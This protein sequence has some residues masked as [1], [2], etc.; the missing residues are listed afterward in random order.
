MPEFGADTG[1]ATVPVH[2]AKSHVPPQAA[3]TTLHSAPTAPPHPRPTPAKP[4]APP[5]VDTFAPAAHTSADMNDTRGVHSARTQMPSGEHPTVPIS[6]YDAPTVAQPSPGPVTPPKPRP[7]QTPAQPPSRLPTPAQQTPATGFDS[8]RPGDVNLTGQSIGGYVVRK[9]LGHGGMGAVCLAHQVSLDRDVALKILPG[10]MASNPDFLMRF[11]RE[12]LSAAQLSHHNIIQVYDIG[13]QEQ[14]HFISMEFVRGEDLGKIVRRDG[15]LQPDDAAGFILQ[16]ARGLKYAHDHG[17]IHRDIK[18]DNIMV[19]EQ[20]IVKIAD[21]GLAKIVNEVEHGAS[22]PPPVDESQRRSKEVIAQAKGELTIMDVAMGTPAYMAPEQGRDA[23]SVDHRADQYSLGCTFYYLLAG[24]APYQG[25]SAVEIISKHQIE[26][27]TPVQAHVKHVPEALSVII[28]KMLEKE[29]AN[30][31]PSMGEVI[32]DIE[33]Y[34]GLESEKGPYTPREEH[35][36]VLEQRQAEFYSVPMLAKRRTGLLAFFGVMALAFVACVFGNAYSWAGGILGL[37]V[38]APFAHF[39][40]NG[41]LTKD[42]LFRRV[43][44]VFFGMTF[45]GWLAAAGSTALVLLVLW[46]L[47]L[48]WSWLAFGALGVGFAVAYQFLV[49]KPLRAARKPA[50]EATQEMLKVLRLRG[51]SEEA[52]MDFVSRFSSTHWEEFFEELFGY[53]EM[54][55][56]RAKWAK[57]DKVKPRKKHATWRDPLHRWLEGI[58]DSRRKAKEKR[59]LAKAE[60]NRLKS[61]GIAEA[62]AEKMAGEMASA[63]MSEGLLQPTVQLGQVDTAAGYISTITKKRRHGVSPVARVYQLVR[64]L[65]GAAIVALYGVWVFKPGLLQALPVDL[66]PWMMKLAFRGEG[67][68]IL[69]L[70]AAVIVAGIMLFLTSATSRVF[71]TTLTFVGALLMVFFRYVVQFGGE[72]ELTPERVFLAGAIMVTVGFLI[73]VVFGGRR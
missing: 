25:K 3:S 28:Q 60:S 4:A 7:A 22:M 36:Q 27:L 49:S 34:L 12:A 56:A 32:K 58:E 35:L 23:S 67:I 47:G 48:F 66:T 70:N 64:F 33:A 9:M 55:L 1:G 44:S 19:N 26:P 61:K 24:K 30:R 68:V 38:L 63:I 54:I 50:L 52:L 17:V 41:P 18:P 37:M 20:G 2:G 62:D 16:A 14:V 57:A 43:R 10:R 11:T 5:P 21:M 46:T 45:K 59:Q 72:A 29:A 65:A 73:S 13:S 53:E 31:Y 69:L 15:K 8:S 39:L 71:F 42:Y 51:V 6:N 40:I